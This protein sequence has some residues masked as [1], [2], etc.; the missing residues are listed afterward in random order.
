MCANNTG[1]LFNSLFGV[2]ILINV[3]SF[4]SSSSLYSS[5]MDDKSSDVSVYHSLKSYALNVNLLV[6]YLGF[7]F[8]F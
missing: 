1:S 8:L 6:S 5:G 2:K 3:P 4:A 7:I